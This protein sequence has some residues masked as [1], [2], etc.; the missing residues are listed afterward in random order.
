M[1]GASAKRERSEGWRF[2][3][4]MDIWEAGAGAARQAAMST[5]DTEGFGCVY[6]VLKNHPKN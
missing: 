4:R 2:G 6:Y 3:S 5:A 1:F